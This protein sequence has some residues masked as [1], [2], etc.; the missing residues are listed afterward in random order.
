MKWAAAAGGGK[1]LQVVSTTKT[2]TFTVS[3]TT[4]TDITGLSVSIT[5]TLSSSTILVLSSVNGSQD[6][7]VDR[8]YLQLERSG[9]PIFVGDSAGSRIRGWEVFL[10]LIQ[11]LLHQQFPQHF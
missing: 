7:N 4:L 9:N 1:V 3:T 5:P 2:D 10:Q 8:G 6:P 11:V